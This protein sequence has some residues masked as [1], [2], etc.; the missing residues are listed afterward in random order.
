MLVCYF[1][2]E[3]AVL[4]GVG[5]DFERVVFEYFVG[6]WNFGSTVRTG[7]HDKVPGAE[8]YHKIA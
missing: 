2:F 8:H 4:A 7:S 5:F 3:V 1:K 6:F